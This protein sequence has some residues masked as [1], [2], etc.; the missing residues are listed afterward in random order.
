MKKAVLGISAF[1]RDSAAAI[2]VD[3]KMSP[4]RKKSGS[5]GRN[6]ILRSPKMHVTTS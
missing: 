1:Y 2:L 3:G 5:R 6:M 4:R